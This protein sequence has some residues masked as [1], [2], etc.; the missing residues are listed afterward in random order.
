M[1]LFLARLQKYSMVSRALLGTIRLYYIL[2]FI[3]S[4]GFNDALIGNDRRCS[5]DLGRDM[6]STFFSRPRLQALSLDSP[7]NLLFNLLQLHSLT[8]QPVRS[9]APP[10]LSSLSTT[11]VTKKAWQQQLNFASVKSLSDL[12]HPSPS[13]ALLQTM[14]RLQ[15]LHLQISPCVWSLVGVS[16]IAL[17]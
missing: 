4:L 9:C 16:C 13:L 15:L 7:N 3:T 8:L 17:T 5:K 6:S 14:T 12:L 11:F 10:I 2:Q 1:T